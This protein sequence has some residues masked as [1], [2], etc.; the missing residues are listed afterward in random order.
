MCIRLPSSHSSPNEK[1][2]VG[3]VRVI[4]T[5]RFTARLSRARPGPGAL[6]V[7][8]LRLRKGV[9]LSRKLPP[10]NIAALCLIWSAELVGGCLTNSP[11]LLP[12][13][14]EG[15]RALYEWTR[16]AS[17]LASYLS[18]H[19]NPNRAKSSSKSISIFQNVARAAFRPELTESV[20]YTPRLNASQCSR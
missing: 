9:S 14:G 13:R 6:P 4:G 11:F 15:A 12:V 10:S 1:E 19:L 8:P 2:G 7:A 18:K 17:L 3:E 5:L 16:L 20:P